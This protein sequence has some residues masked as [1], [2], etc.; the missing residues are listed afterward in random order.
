[1]RMSK[2]FFLAAAFASVATAGCFQQGEESIRQ[3]IEYVRGRAFE[4]WRDARE[5]GDSHEAKAEGP[6]S[7]DDAIK[8]VNSKHR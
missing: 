6:L 8:L 5:R 2:L 4:E 1:M 3:E 7:L